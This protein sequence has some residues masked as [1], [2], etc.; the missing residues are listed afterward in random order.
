MSDLPDQQGD[1]APADFDLDAWI[2]GSKPT[3]RSV[4]LVG[5]GDLVAEAEAVLRRYEVAK[6]IPK[7]DRGINDDTPES[8]E[9]QLEQLYAEMEASRTTWFLRALLPEQVQAANDAA[10]KAAGEGGEPEYT[11]HLLAAGVSRVVKP[12]GS[13][14]HGITADQI[15]RLRDRVGPSQMLRLVETLNAAISEEPKIQAP[16]SLTSLPDPDG[17]AS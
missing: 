3:E 4:T 14:A 12:D 9:A 16:F 13:V 8:L 6:R 15:I 2:D 5:R 7:H 1:V 17:Q 10:E 11:A